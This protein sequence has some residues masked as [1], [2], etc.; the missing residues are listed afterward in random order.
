M[1]IYGKF[2]PSQVVIPSSLKEQFTKDGFV[3]IPNA[4]TGEIVESLIKKVDLYLAR[5]E[6]ESSDNNLNLESLKEKDLL[7]CPLAYDRSFYD[8]L[9]LNEVALNFVRAFLGENFQLHLQNSIVN[10]PVRTH[11]QSSWHRDFPYQP[12]L[13]STPMSINCFYCLTDFNEETGGTYVVPGSHKIPD[14]EI[15]EDFL[16]K[17]KITATLNAGGLMIFDSLLWHRAGNNISTSARYGINNVFTTPIIKQQISLPE[18]LKAD[19]CLD[20]TDEKLLG[21]RWNV[22]KSVMD[23]RTQKASR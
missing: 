5:Q 3:L 8:E 4:L 20:V 13:T 15:D 7:R 19:Y 10:R 9:C 14:S 21:Y 1:S 17:N 18:F 12:F 2:I 11:H 6:K 16:E 22:P 23:L